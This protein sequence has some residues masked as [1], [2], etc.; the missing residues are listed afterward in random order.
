MTPT[1]R[2]RRGQRLRR[3]QRDLASQV[4]AAC[5]QTLLPQHCLHPADS[6]KCQTTALLMD[7]WRNSSTAVPK[8]LGAQQ[9]LG[10]QDRAP[11]AP[12]GLRYRREGAGQEKD[13]TVLLL[14]LL[15]LDISP[16][17]AS[18]DLCASV[19]SLPSVTELSQA[20]NT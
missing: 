7:M 16:G 20:L 6:A 12:Q 8:G 1:Q 14:M 10:E 18:P 15:A 13:R 5:S 19:P 17:H 4:A 9:E 11:A 2:C 3:A